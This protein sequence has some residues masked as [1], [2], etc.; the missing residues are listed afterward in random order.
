MVR[1]FLLNEIFHDTGPGTTIYGDPSIQI[2]LIV[3]G[4]QNPVRHQGLYPLNHLNPL[5]MGVTSAAVPDTDLCFSHG[6]TGLIA[7]W[8]SHFRRLLKNAQVQGA[9]NPE[10]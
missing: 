7:Y 8:I 9:R 1:T 2:F 6:K 3:P 4:K 5:V 10:E